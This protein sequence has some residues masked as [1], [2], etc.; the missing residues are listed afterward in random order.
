MC[1][2]LPCMVAVG[3]ETTTTTMGVVFCVFGRG[4]DYARI[5]TNINLIKVSTLTVS[6]SFGYF[7]YFYLLCEI[8]ALF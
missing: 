4:E 3:E 2:W 8:V 6:S 1:V 5:S 7:S